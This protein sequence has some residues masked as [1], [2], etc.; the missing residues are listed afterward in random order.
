VRTCQD[1]E[2][3]FC[4]VEA[5]TD[6]GTPAGGDTSADDAALLIGR[7]R[8]NTHSNCGGR[9]VCLRRPDSQPRGVH[10]LLRQERP[11]RVAQH[12]RGELF[13]H[14][15]LAPGRGARGVRVGPV[16][17]A[18][19]AANLPGGADL[20]PHP[21][22]HARVHR[23]APLVALHQGRGRELG[24]FPQ[25]GQFHSRVRPLTL[26]LFP[27]AIVHQVS[28]DTLLAQRVGNHPE[29]IE[30]LY[31]A[32]LFVLRSVVKLS[33]YLPAY[34]LFTGNATE[35]ENVQV[36]TCAMVC[37]ASVQRALIVLGRALPLVGEALPA[38]GQVDC[39]V[40]HVVPAHL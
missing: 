10:G 17:V 33:Q 40:L 20:L 25:L 9:R 5:D 27:V 4:I 15:E 26:L 31:F 19:G 8:K 23:R 3:N 38:A 37:V 2:R 12:L 21:L 14:G 34:D 22:R 24:T 32:Y 1:D 29:R 13:Q 36:C 39:D 18:A 6:P 16:T 28:N 11:P 7:Q 30:N 35:D